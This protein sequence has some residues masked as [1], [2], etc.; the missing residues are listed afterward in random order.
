MVKRNQKPL[1]QRI[2]EKF[3]FYHDE[4]TEQTQLVGAR[5][6]YILAA[7]LLPLVAAYQQFVNGETGVFWVMITAVFLSLLYLLFRRYQLGGTAPI[8]EYIEQSLNASFRHA[9]IFLLLSLSGYAWYVL[10]Y[11][12]PV[13]GNDAYPGVYW[14]PLATF[15]TLVPLFGIH[16][17]RRTY[18]PRS[19][20][21]F[22]I[23]TLLVF[24]TTYVV[25]F[26]AGS[27][28]P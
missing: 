26:F 8:D 16:L 5:Y 19:W 17:R 13:L 1:W 25:G 2:D 9:Y 27:A 21:L 24:L 28:T 11:V 22:I 14:W 6:S 20:W 3:G 12:A 23:V 10:I 4:R 18:E 15:V 7:L